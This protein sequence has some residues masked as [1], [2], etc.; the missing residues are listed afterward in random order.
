MAQIPCARAM[1]EAPRLGAGQGREG[2]IAPALRHPRRPT[3][4]RRDQRTPRN[5]A[6][7]SVGVGPLISCVHAP[8]AQD[9]SNSLIKGDAR[10]MR[11]VGDQAA[12]IP[13][14]N[15]KRAKTDHLKGRCSLD[16][17][18]KWHADRPALRRQGEG[19]RLRLQTRLEW[20]AEGALQA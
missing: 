13:R 17:R 7:G 5:A 19:K 3:S 18:R 12:P 2:M 4:R 6:R 15:T 8:R 20:C 16:A 1:G 10:C 14:R 9:S 11:A